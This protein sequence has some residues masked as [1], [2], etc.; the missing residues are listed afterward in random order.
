MNILIYG[1]GSLGLLFA[2][3]LSKKH[4]VEII[5]KKEKKEA[6]DKKGLTFIKGSKKELSELTLYTNIK[7]VS[8]K[9]E[10]IILSVKSFDIDNSLSDI[11]A[12]FKDIPVITIQNGVYAESAAKKSLG[13]ENVLPAY[14]MIGSKTINSHT[15][16]EF[17]N[18]G[19]KIG[20]LSKKSKEK[21][22]KINSVLNE[23]GIKSVLSDDIMRQ[24]WH[25][26]MFYCAGATL[27]S[28]TGTK[29]LEDENIKWMV[30][31]VLSEIT[32]VLK[33]LNLDFDAE[34]LSSEVFEFL[35][36]FKP[37]SWSASVGEDL[38]KGK[39]T[40]IDYLNG[41]IVKLAEKLNIEV[42]L[43]KSLTSMVKTVEKTGYFA[44]MNIR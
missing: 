15:I 34:K 24:K 41:Y 17:L 44:N 2:R 18:E 28:L 33:A 30:E 40:E 29:N 16:E 19:M 39:K 26:M 36:S 35:M 13:K 11:S 20:Y 3:Y 14:V 23:C 31:A 27:N 37:K 8:L 32:R 9:P 22:K 4:D 10:F 1:G 5:S 7:E 42:P 38:R 6:I 21:A 43:N 25:K 12:F